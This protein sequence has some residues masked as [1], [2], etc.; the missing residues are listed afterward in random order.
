[1]SE[2]AAAAPPT[3]PSRRRV[4]ASRLFSTLLLWSLLT[5]AFLQWQNVWLIIAITGFFGVAGAVEYY[6]LL[7][8]DP[9]ARSFNALGF[10]ICVLYWGSVI[11]HTT[12]RHNVPPMWLDLAALTASGLPKASPAASR[13]RLPA[14]SS[15]MR[16]RKR[17]ERCSVSAQTYASGRFFR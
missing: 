3:T 10:V 7:R 12:T 14:S 16:A 17:A 6:R 8:N 5:V 13:A 1:M 2:S 11:W 4:F 15:R 9:H